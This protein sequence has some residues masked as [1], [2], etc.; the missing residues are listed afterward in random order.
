MIEHTFSLILLDVQLSC[1]KN[2]H[3]LSLRLCLIGFV[4]EY[5]GHVGCLFI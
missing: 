1:R 4:T 2:T 3:F 5:V